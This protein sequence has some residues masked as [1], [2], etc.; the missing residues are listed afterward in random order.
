M[1]GERPFHGLGL[2][3][4]GIMKAIVG[5]NLP[6]RPI[7]TYQSLDDSLWHL[8]QLCW[9]MDPELRPWMHQVVNK[10][11]RA[12]V[13]DSI[14]Y[15]SGSPSTI[16]S[17]LPKTPPPAQLM[18]TFPSGSSAISEPNV[19]FPSMM[20]DNGHFEPSSPGE[21][22]YTSVSDRST[23][24][25]YPRSFAS[26]YNDPQQE[27]DKPL[28]Q[29][30][31]S[32]FLSN[33]SSTRPLQI[34]R[35]ETP[36]VY[37]IVSGESA[38]GAPQQQQQNLSPTSF[39]QRS[40]NSNSNNSASP[41]SYASPNSFR[42]SILFQPLK[43]TRP[44]RNPNRPYGENSPT[45]PYSEQSMNSLNGYRESTYSVLDESL[46]RFS[47]DGTVRCGSV[48]A[49]V[50]RLFTETDCEYDLAKQLPH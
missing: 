1:T 37:T 15:S 23:V 43:P 9:K 31:V 38:Q 40:P 5:N 2:N 44:N 41:N 4:V 18:G 45:S 36:S 27:G 28:P 32:R 29:R 13:T 49:L 50:R 11:R 33:V 14:D 46:L 22:N 8:M 25:R 24:S 30:P 26:F 17:A 19:Q 12:M 3:D 20:D 10:L 21:S 16:T 42:Q 47:E 39:N 6:T 34:P 35:R 7:D 48:P